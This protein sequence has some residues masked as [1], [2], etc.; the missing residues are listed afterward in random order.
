MHAYESMPDFSTQNGLSQALGKE[1][2]ACCLLVEMAGSPSVLCS[3]REGLAQH[4]GVPGSFALPSSV[5]VG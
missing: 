4:C 3:G 5:L 2:K 1:Q